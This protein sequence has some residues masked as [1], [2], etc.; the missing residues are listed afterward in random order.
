MTYLLAK[1]ELTLEE[2]YN[3]ARDLLGA[4]VDTTAYTALWLLY[5]LARNPMAQ[6]NLHKELNNILGKDG[7]VTA[8]SLAQLPYLK[9]CVKESAR[10]TP[11]VAANRRIPYNDVVLSGFLVPAKTIIHLDFYATGAS[12]KHFKNAL[13][14]KPERWLRKNK[15]E[16]HPFSILPFGYGPRMCLGN[17]V[18]ELEIYLL[19][20]KIF[21]RFRLEYH[22]E[23]LEMIQKLL[24]VPEKPVRIK[25]VER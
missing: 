19:I 14:Y 12:E 1:K 7:N 6:E 8:E 17:R 18:A 15:K 3:V 24:A 13:E 2:V 21:Q 20:I 5:H 25:F 23:P 9:A 4:G 10:M 11:L 16:F 22:H